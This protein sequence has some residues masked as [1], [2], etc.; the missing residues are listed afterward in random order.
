MNLVSCL[1]LSCPDPG[2]GA[3]D[4]TQMRRGPIPSVSPD[5]IVRATGAGGVGAECGLPRPLRVERTLTQAV[6]T[7]ILRR[8]ELWERSMSRVGP[9]A[10]WW[11]RRVG[12]IGIDVAAHLG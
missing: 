5:R 12:L 2:T 3:H 11:R 1:C 10:L 7:P 6:Q 4:S 8:L 9:Y